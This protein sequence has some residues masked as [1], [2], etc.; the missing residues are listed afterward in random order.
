MT[1]P[2]PS[3]SW[4]RVVAAVCSAGLPLAVAGALVDSLRPV[5]WPMVLLALAGPYLVMIGHLSL[6]RELSPAEKSLWRRELWWGHRSIVAVWT[7][8]LTRDLHE[9]S[10]QFAEEDREWWRP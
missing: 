5:A 3:A 9:A 10:R 2:S 1:S 4:R 8:L 7:Y 6:S